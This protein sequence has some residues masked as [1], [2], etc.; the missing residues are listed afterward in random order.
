MSH[1]YCFA[2]PL[3]PSHLEIYYPNLHKAPRRLHWFRDNAALTPRQLSGTL[4]AICGYMGSHHIDCFI[5]A[6]KTRPNGVVFRGAAP[7]VR[8]SGI[9]HPHVKTMAFNVFRSSVFHPDYGTL[10]QF[11]DSHA[12]RRQQ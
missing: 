5:T 6:I 11:P 4:P 2:L 9:C 1:R 8:L 12:V 10:V 3:L 7:V